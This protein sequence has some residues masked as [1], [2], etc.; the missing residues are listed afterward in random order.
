[1]VAFH[2]FR[3]ERGVVSDLGQAAVLVEGFVQ[4]QVPLCDYGRFD[5]KQSL[6]DLLLVENYHL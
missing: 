1:M 2:L 6:C 5:V 4:C 3:D